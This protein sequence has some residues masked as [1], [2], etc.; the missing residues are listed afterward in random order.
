MAEAPE[1]GDRP[2][3]ALAAVAGLAMLFAC[4]GDSGSSDGGNNNTG[5]NDSG[6]GNDAGT[7]DAGT[8]GGYLIGGRILT[9]G[10]NGLVLQTP[11][12][13]NLAI[14]LQ[15]Y[16]PGFQFANRVPTGTH[17]NVTVASQPVTPQCG[18]ICTCTILDGGVGIVGAS[19]VSNVL[20]ACAIMLP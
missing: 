4:G 6:T 16:Q 20:V 15:S 2:M 18:G 12:E 19:D 14:P 5:G 1:P 7:N 13:P 3:K 11:G 17:Y 8:G 10:A 9:G